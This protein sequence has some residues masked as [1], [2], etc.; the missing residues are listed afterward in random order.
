MQDPRAGFWARAW[1]GEERLWKVWWYVGG[2]LTIAGAITAKLIA[3][4]YLALAFAVVLLAAY[5]AWCGMAWRCAPNVDSKIWTPIARTLIVLGLL[6]TAV[7]LFKVFQPAS[8]S[9]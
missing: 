3:D 9:P 1:R 6:R 7:E 5:F 8:Q 2:P 4:R